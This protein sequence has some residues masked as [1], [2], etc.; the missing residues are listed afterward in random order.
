MQLAARQQGM[1]YLEYSKTKIVDKCSPINIVISREC[2][3]LVALHMTTSHLLDFQE[4]DWWLRGMGRESQVRSAKKG[5][6]G[7]IKEWEWKRRI[8]FKSLAGKNCKNLMATK[9]QTMQLGRS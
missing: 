5:C 3:K 9:I 1:F 2:R 8:I 4:G 6:I 7:R